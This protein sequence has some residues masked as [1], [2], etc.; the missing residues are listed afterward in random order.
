MTWKQNYHVV[1]SKVMPTALQPSRRS[2]L[3]QGYFRYSP[4]IIFKWS[5]VGTPGVV[6]NGKGR[7]VM[8]MDMI[9]LIQD[10][11]YKKQESF[12]VILANK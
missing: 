5:D 8:G 9:L 10:Y 6:L 1:W 2:N 3:G 7:G 12:E 4:A 11:D